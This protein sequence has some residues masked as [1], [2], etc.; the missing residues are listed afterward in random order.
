MPVERLRAELAEEWRGC[1]GVAPKTDQ[2][3]QA[4]LQLGVAGQE[5][6]VGD[7]G[8]FVSQRPHGI[9]PQR[10]VPRRVRDHVGVQSLRIAQ[11]IG[12]RVEKERSHEAAR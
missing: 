3:F 12:H 6:G 11:I 9:E 10:L 7:S 5:R 4:K 8:N 1:H 2:V